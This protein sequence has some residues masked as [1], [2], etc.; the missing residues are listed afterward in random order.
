MY[1]HNVKENFT[2]WELNSQSVQRV[3]HRFWSLLQNWVKHLGSGIT[4]KTKM[5]KAGGVRRNRIF[6]FTVLRCA[7]VRQ[8]LLK[9]GV[10]AQQFAAGSDQPVHLFAA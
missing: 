1:F 3:N 10:F 5:N 2:N 7:Q 8:E 6:L 9:A 4:D